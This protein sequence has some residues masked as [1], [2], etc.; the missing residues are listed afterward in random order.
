[1]SSFLLAVVIFILI[2]IALEEIAMA[3][4]GMIDPGFQDKTEDEDL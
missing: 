3:L 1:M 4:S 2:V